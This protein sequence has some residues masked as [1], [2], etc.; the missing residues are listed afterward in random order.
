[1]LE[2]TKVSCEAHIH[3]RK[4]IAMA[5]AT[6]SSIYQLKVTLQGVRPPVW[7][8]LLVPSAVPLSTLHGILQVALGWTDSHLHSF[9]V[10]GETYG[11]P[12]REFANDMRS[13]ARMRL[14]RALVREK[15]AIFYEYDFGDGWRHKI[16][17]ERIVPATPQT[18][19]P[20][21]IA[22]ARACPPEDCGGVWGYANLLA[23]IANPSH[24]EHE[25]MLEWLGDEFDPAHFHVEEVNAILA[26]YA[27]RA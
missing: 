18:R 2:L 12:D 22:G 7:R 23:A 24:P 27:G 25:E 6:Q 10:Q 8:R 26:A 9:E 1:L 17:L 4:I 11:V 19:A 14:D 20:L 13:E 15:D 5:K 3:H 16:V 21:C